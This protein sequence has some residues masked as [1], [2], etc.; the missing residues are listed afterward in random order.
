MEPAVAHFFF[1]PEP[2]QEGQFDALFNW[3]APVSGEK[4]FEHYQ[5]M[6]RGYTAFQYRKMALFRKS[7]NTHLLFFDDI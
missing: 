1:L 5:K 3:R 6:E 4:V 2:N 7:G